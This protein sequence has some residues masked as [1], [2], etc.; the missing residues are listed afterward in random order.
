MRA[1]GGECSGGS[2]GAARPLRRP[3]S[4]REDQG[5][6]EGAPVR[7]DDGVSGAWPPADALPRNSGALRDTV[8]NY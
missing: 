2:P 7:P 3:G 6:P 5:G 4:A 1:P 8:E